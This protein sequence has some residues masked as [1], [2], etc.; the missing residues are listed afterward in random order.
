MRK[1][2]IHHPIFR[3]VAPF[4]VGLVAYLLVLLFFNSVTQLKEVFFSNEAVLCIIIAY[5]QFEGMR[6]ALVLLKRVWDNWDSNWFLISQISGTLLASLLI[7]SLII[8]I[9]FKYIIGYSEFNTELFVINGAF[10]MMSIG[11][12]VLHLSVFYL[13]QQNKKKL[14]QEQAI[15]QNIELKLESFKNQ[16]N[17]TFLYK[18]LES[19]IPLLHHS[20]ELAEDF[21]DQL[22]SIYRY[23]LDNRKEDLI[24]LKEELKSVSK[25]I[26]LENYRFHQNIELK[27]DLVEDEQE[28]FVIP[29]TIHWLIEYLIESTLISD[30]QPMTISC[31]YESTD[32][33]VLATALNQ[34]LLPA[35]QS[36]EGLEKAQKTYLFYTDIPIVTVKVDGQFLIKV[37]PLFLEKPLTRNNSLKVYA[38]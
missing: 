23:T 17:P 22:A 31:Y 9:H 3:I 29:N 38:F 8:F 35:A 20:A 16:V 33:L 36:K 10:A 26:E 4:F 13:N 34:R 5:C 37:P 6:F 19:L 12:S 28:R 30:T 27:I 1:A 2:F 18:S 15:Q 11:Y 32:Y 25:L 7:T 21:I 14:S 24:A